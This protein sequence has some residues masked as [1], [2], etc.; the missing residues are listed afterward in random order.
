[1]RFKWQYLNTYNN[2]Y[3]P[4]SDQRQFALDLYITSSF[5]YPPNDCGFVY[6]RHTNR[7]FN[8]YYLSGGDILEPIIIEGALACNHYINYSDLGQFNVDVSGLVIS[9]S[10]R[11]MANYKFKS[12]WLETRRNNLVKVQFW[13]YLILWIKATLSSVAFIF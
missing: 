1:M 11:H 7:F 6:Q 8:T 12:F 13:C 10:K 4:A 2:V 5:A 9:Y 3:Y